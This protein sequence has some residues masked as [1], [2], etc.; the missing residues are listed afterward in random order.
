MKIDN[1]VYAVGIYKGGG[2]QVLKEFIKIN[3]NFYYYFDSRLN[4][5][6]Y[7]GIKNYKIVKQS[8]TNIFLANLEFKK[9]KK[10]YFFCKWITTIIKFAR[11]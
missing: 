11:Q 3:K 6:H 8:I 9:K 5:I 4:S 7:K 10:K 2:L 1:I